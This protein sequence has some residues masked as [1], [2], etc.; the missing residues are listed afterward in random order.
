M[1]SPFLSR[2]RR[3][4]LRQHLF[5]TVRTMQTAHWIYR[6]SC[7]SFSISL[8]FVSPHIH[9]PGFCFHIIIVIGA[10]HK[11]PIDINGK[12]RKNFFPVHI[13]TIVIVSRLLFAFRC[14]V[15]SI[16]S[17]SILLSMRY[18][19]MN[20]HWF[21][22]FQRQ[23]IVGFAVPLCTVP[24]RTH[25]RWNENE[26]KLHF[27]R[28][29]S[30]IP[31]AK[32]NWI[33]AAGGVHRARYTYLAIILCNICDCCECEST[34]RKRRWRNWCVCVLLSYLRTVLHTCSCVV[35]C[36]LNDL[37]CSNILSHLNNEYGYQS[38]MGSA[39]PFDGADEQSSICSRHRQIMSSPVSLA[40]I[41]PYAFCRRWLC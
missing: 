1:A 2:L 32:V 30:I 20:K 34:R 40:P 36:L 26:K 11:K 3:A 41:A 21:H 19:P 4:P 7:H 13:W 16:E 5:Q 39:F 28:S 29:Q 12:R 22:N 8:V 9:A 31:L 6:M 17:R 38:A 15:L 18:L 10:N 37:I 24:S 25:F 35:C 23:Y 33:S 27:T 14:L